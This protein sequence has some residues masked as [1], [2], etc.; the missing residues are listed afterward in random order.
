MKTLETRLQ[1]VLDLH[2]DP[3]WG[4]EFWLQREKTLDFN[5]RTEIVSLHDIHRFGLTPTET[6][7][8]ESIQHFLPRRYHQ[9]LHRCINSETGGTTGPPKRTVF[10]EEEFHEAFVQPF[11]AAAELINFPRDLNWLYIGPSGP[12]VIGKGARRCAV[13]MGSVDP[14][15]VDFDPRWVR[16]LASNPFAKNR[17][18]EH[19]LDQVASVLD[20]QEIGVL[21]A[22]PPILT[23][24]GQRMPQSQREVIRGIH[25]GGMTA[26]TTF[27]EDLTTD[28]FPNAVAIAGYGNS[29]AGVCPQVGGRPRDL[30]DYFAHGNRLVLDIHEPDD[31]GV[32]GV[33]FH[34]L[35][36]SCFLPN[37]VERDV[38][39][40]VPNDDVAIN[41]GFHTT[42]IHDPHPPQSSKDAVQGGLY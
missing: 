21:F 1:E 12:H 32:G 9:E 27:W 40:L 31:K 22:T 24:L 14:F 37:V 36:H 6:L 26:D 17:Y 5:P 10:L 25:L 7:A 35:D 15:T 28:Y 30:P 19:V 38:A 4:S 16:K 39:Q 2:F 20:T 42:G 8:T 29:L 18:V 33:M 3:K 11:L 34:R 23:A 41:K 13:E